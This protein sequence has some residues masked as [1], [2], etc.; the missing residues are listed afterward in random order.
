MIT[1]LY[2]KVF[3]WVGGSHLGLVMLALTASLVSCEEEFK[4]LESVTLPAAETPPP[5]Q[6]EERE[7]Q[8]RDQRLAMD[9]DYAN[10]ILLPEE[11]LKV[12]RNT[13]KKA[14]PKPPEPEPPEPQP[15]PEPEPA[16]ASYEEFI[17]LHGRPEPRA[18]RP[19]PTPRSV[20]VPEIRV[21]HSELNQILTASQSDLVASMSQSEQRAILSYGQAL[22]AR[23]DAA[24]I[25]PPSL[26]G[27]NLATSVS[28]RVTRSGE[29]VDVRIVRSSGQSMFDDSVREVFRTVGRADPPP[30]Q[31]A[32]T[33]QIDFKNI[34]RP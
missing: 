27:Q 13:S 18:P 23:L 30:P 25:R 19:T 26:S 7:E 29:L 17:R 6:R 21:D 22:S 10:L 8:P 4:V 12:R 16:R 24:W 33:Y 3:K 1:P 28:F 31:A 15:E 9:L 20:D 34:L 5:P 32:R 2:K 14:E 11:A